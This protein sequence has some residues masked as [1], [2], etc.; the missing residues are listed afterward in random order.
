M[1]HNNLNHREKKWIFLDP[2]KG[3]AMGLLNRMVE[4]GWRKT[5]KSTV[6]M[7]RKAYE[8]AEYA[9]VNP[10]LSVREKLFPNINKVNEWEIP[11]AMKELMN[12]VAGMCI[13]Y[14]VSFVSSYRKGDRAFV[15]KAVYTEL[16][17]WD[18]R[19]ADEEEVERVICP[20]FK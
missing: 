16:L 10:V 2:N 17:L 4:E 5:A 7:A 15:A 12:S 6:K 14:A 1:S 3:R 8:Q 20:R 9:G 18:S 19:I 13:A 11:S